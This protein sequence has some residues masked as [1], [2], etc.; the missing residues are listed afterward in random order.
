MMSLASIYPKLHQWLTHGGEMVIRPCDSGVEVRLGDAGGFP[1]DARAQSA[2]LD[3]A[4][5]AAEAFVSGWL[6]RTRQLQ[7]ELLSDP[8]AEIRDQEFIRVTGWP[9]IRNPHFER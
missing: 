7:Q 3:A 2:T 8:V 9:P 1:P 5:A 6:E 4:L